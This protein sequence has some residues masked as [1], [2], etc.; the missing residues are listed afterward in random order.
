MGKTIDKEL[1][2][3]AEKK[4]VEDYI[5]KGKLDFG[6]NRVTTYSGDDGSTII[7]IANS[8]TNISRKE[9]NTPEYFRTAG[10]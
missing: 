10:G 2:I 4:M 7:R 1:K 5:R 9:H 3:E 8:S 6:E